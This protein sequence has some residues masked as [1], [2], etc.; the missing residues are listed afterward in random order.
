MTEANVIDSWEPDYEHS[1]E[2]CGQSP[3][4]L[5][6]TGGKVVYQGDLCGPC[7]W[8]EAACLDPEVWNK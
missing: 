8:G 3:V 2:N 7:T 5:G 4:V 1:C 6:V